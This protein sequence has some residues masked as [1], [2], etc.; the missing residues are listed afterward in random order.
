MK[1]CLFCKIIKGEVPSLKIYE[2]DKVLAFMD[3]YYV[4]KG[5]TLVIPKKHSEN[6][7]DIE[8]EDLSDTME[9]VRKISK[10]VKKGVN[11]DG[12]NIHI[13]NGSDAGQVIPHIH[14]HIIPRFKKDDKK[15]WGSSEYKKGER[16]E[17]FEK[18]RK[19]I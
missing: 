15:M 1:N 4:G 19:E 16:E 10:A 17:I 3:I 9:V 14:I 5:H 18:I 2:N 13:N 7:F 6:I 12:I 8:K 11:A